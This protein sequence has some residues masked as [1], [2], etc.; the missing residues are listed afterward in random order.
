MYQLT[1]AK[2][3]GDIKT[4]RPG[5]Y[6]TRYSPNFTQL[7]PDH[8]TCSFLKPS[9]LPREHAAQIPFSGTQTLFKHTSLPC[10]YQVPTYSW[11]ER[12]HVW[13]KCLVQ[14]ENTAAQLSPSS[15][16]TCDLLPASCA[17]YW[18][19]N[20]HR[21]THLLT[22]VSDTHV[23]THRLTHTDTQ[24]WDAYWHTD[25]TSILTHMMMCAGMCIL[26][27]ILKV[28][29]HIYWTHTLLDTCT[30]TCQHVLTHI[31][32]HV[33]NSCQNRYQICCKQRCGGLI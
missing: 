31:L 25:W 9:Q 27:H 28:Y 12:V 16:L 3:K 15:N 19:H 8:R 33:P 2:G 20:A 7:L 6:H 22:H 18:A 26:T 17:H 11:V 29:W 24:G 14:E 32:T 1:P 30:D 5:I 21:L 4:Y 13:V 10:F 23:L